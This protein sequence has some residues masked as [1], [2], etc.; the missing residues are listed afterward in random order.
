MHSV[1]YILLTGVQ[2]RTQRPKLRP[3]SC[4]SSAWRTSWTTTPHQWLSW[5]ASHW[6]RWL[7]AVAARCSLQPTLEPQVTTVSEPLIPSWSFN[8]SV[9]HDI[10]DRLPSRC[11]VLRAGTLYLASE[12]DVALLGDAQAHLLLRASGP[13]QQRLAAIAA[14]GVLSLA[15]LSAAVL[16]DI[17]LPAMLPLDWRYG[18]HDDILLEHST[19]KLCCSCLH[20][21]VSDFHGLCHV[22]RGAAEVQWTPGKDGQPTSEALAALWSRIIAFPPAD[23]QVQMRRTSYR[24]IAHSMILSGNICLLGTLQYAVRGMLWMGCLLLR[25]PWFFNTQR[26]RALPLMPV[27][28]GRLAAPTARPVVS[29]GAWA[30]GVG[31]ALMRLGCRL[32]DATRLPAVVLQVGRGQGCMAS[33]CP[34]VVGSCA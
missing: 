2:A 9:H 18:W 6:L 3:R 16:A 13:L 20:G 12:E 4:C 30:P 23:A 32:L 33:T 26:F 21:C 5:P 7:M 1:S 10:V 11:R 28:G 31:S 17:F 27:E 34:G 24:M 8:V 25:L 22:S 15:P 29:L 19:T 14:G